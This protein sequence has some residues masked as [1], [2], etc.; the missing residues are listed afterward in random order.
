MLAAAKTDN[1]ANELRFCICF[2]SDYIPTANSPEKAQTAFG[3]SLAFQRE[4]FM[5]DR[6][7]CTESK[8]TGTI[9]RDCNCLEGCIRH[10]RRLRLQLSNSRESRHP[11]PRKGDSLIR[12][13]RLP[14]TPDAPLLSAVTDDASRRAFRTPKP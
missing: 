13:F 5:Q 2:S 12:G 1:A 4:F 7:A 9:V 3:I 14:Q 6:K 11:R 10:F 8:L